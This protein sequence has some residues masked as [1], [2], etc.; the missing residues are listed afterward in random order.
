M[1][2]FMQ[3]VVNHTETIEN[4]MAMAIESTANA[5][6]VYKHKNIMRAIRVLDL[7][8]G[9]KVQAL[10]RTESTNRGTKAVGTTGYK[11][12]ELPVEKLRQKAFRVYKNTTQEAANG[13]QKVA[14][15]LNNATREELLKCWDGAGMKPASIIRLVAR[16][17]EKKAKKSTKKNNSK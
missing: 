16:H 15:I 5:V 9:L 3:I 13:L 8:Q 7:E 2:N 12:I 11:N 10:A 4:I 17:Q 14:D 6:R 1:A